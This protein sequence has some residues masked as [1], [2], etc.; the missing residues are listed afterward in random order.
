MTPTL[1]SYLD[2]CIADALPR[3][4]QW[5]G[6]NIALQISEIEVH[7]WPQGWSDTTCGGGGCGGQQVTSAQTCVIIGPC[8]DACI[9]HSR[10]AY[11]LPDPTPEFWEAFDSRSLPGA[12]SPARKKLTK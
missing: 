11:Y 2:R 5:P 12:R 1:G 3:L 7:S 10:F 9:Y 4:K 6:S 8:G